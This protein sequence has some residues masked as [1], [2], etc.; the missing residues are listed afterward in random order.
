MNDTVLPFPTSDEER[1]RRLR[2]EVER[3]AQ[4]STVE[5]MLYVTTE[6][7][8]AKYGVDCAMLERMVEAVVKENEK[9]SRAEQVEQRRIEARV[10]RKQE[11]EDRRVRRDRKEEVALSRKEVERERKAAERARKAAE[12]IEREQE[13]KR[14]KREAAFTEIAELPKLTHEVRLKEAA[15]RLSEDY[16]FLVEEFEVFFA[17]RS[18]PEDLEPWS[19]P[20]DTAEL[21]AA[22]EV[23]FRRYVVA[24]DAIVTASVLWGAFT[25]AV[26]IATHA[27]KLIF[28][29]PERD[30]GKSIA[31]DVL[32]W[33]V[34]RPYAAVEA[35]GAAVY[36]IVDRLRPT[37]CLDEADT[38]F[39]RRGNVL[40]HIANDSWSNNK[41]KV[42]RVGKGGR[43]DE[44]DVYGAQLISM[45]GLR[46]PDTVLSRSIV[47]LIWPKLASEL[48][49]EFTYQDD[50][51]FKVIRRKLARWVVDNAGALRDAKPDFPPGFNNRIRVNWK[52][53]L[54]IAELA[55][56]K[57][58]KRV[59][60]AALELETDRDEPSG[61]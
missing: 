6:S 45:K 17:A 44:F 11:R 12:R 54:A 53:L 37:L 35:T 60:N 29:F 26:E 47:C 5:W 43:I 21:L 22:I 24:S 33:V 36:R 14:V 59:R 1:A 20:V 15:E 27:V 41:R 10:E 39:A 25:Y 3:L 46:V 4:L 30:A 34:L 31:Q 28:T 8:A 2:V 40:A 50:D 32:R 16:A 51:E 49:E 52:M 38:I 18:I 9:K 42:P 55:G 58:P 19:E 48:V 61:H 57:W 23:K 7:Y 56:G 13:A